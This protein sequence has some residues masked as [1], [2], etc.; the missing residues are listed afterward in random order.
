MRL[1]AGKLKSGLYQLE[2]NI[3]SFETAVLD[4]TEAD[5]KLKEAVEEEKVD[6]EEKDN[7]EKPTE[8][9]QY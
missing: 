1:L 9:A 2:N 5:A 3:Q 8:G 7:V 6:L 4:L